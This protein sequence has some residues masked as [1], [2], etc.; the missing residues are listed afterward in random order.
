MYIHGEK[1]PVSRGEACL[2]FNDRGDEAPFNSGVPH[3]VPPVLVVAV[4]VLSLTPTPVR[5]LMKGDLR[6]GVR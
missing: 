6:D 3:H 2:A 1:R 4:P 5:N